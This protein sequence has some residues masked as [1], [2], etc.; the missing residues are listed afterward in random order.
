VTSL[1]AAAAPLVLEA[2]G[3]EDVRA[4]VTLEQECFTHPW[5]ARYFRDAIKEPGRGRVVVLRDP[6]APLEPERGIRAYCAYETVLDEVHVHNLAVAP[7]HRRRGLARRLLRLVLEGAARRGARA[8][9]LEVRQSNWA[10]LALYRSFGFA[11]VGVRKAYYER[12]REDALVLR[13]ILEI[14]G[15]AC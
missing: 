8:A 5:T 11:A 12:P 14:P 9:L 3:E 13:M 10:A 7:G 15:S 6:A 1:D 4:L 2:A